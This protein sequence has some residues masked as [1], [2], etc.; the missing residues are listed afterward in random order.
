[1]CGVAFYTNVVHA[2]ISSGTTQLYDPLDSTGDNPLEEL[3]QRIISYLTM[4]AAPIITVMVL[5]GGI[6]IL[7][8]QDNVTKYKKG[9][10]TVKHAAIGAAIVILADGILLVVKG[11]LTV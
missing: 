1:M 4:I 7:I 6:Q 8:A 5:W 11:F 2:Q 9:L 10:D 3:L